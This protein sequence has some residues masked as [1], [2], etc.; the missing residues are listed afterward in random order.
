MKKVLLSLAVIVS[1]ISCNSSEEVVTVS[2]NAYSFERNG[3]STVNFEGQTTRI[4]MANELAKALKKQSTETLQS[5]KGKFAHSA[6]ENNFSE[7]DLN[8][9]SKNIR[10]K[11][12]ASTDY[13]TANTTAATAIKADFDSWISGQVNTVFPNWNQ[14]ASKG[15]AGQIQEAGGGAIRWVN[16]KGLEYDQAI[17]KGLIGGL[18]V[19][20]ILNNYLSKAVLDAGTNVEDNNAELLLSGK[21]YTTME[22]KWDEA[23]GYLYGNEPSITAPVLNT[24]SYLN[25]YLSRVEGDD[26]FKGIAKEIYD[27]F[28]LGRAAIVAKDYNLRNAQAE[29]IKEKI[30]EIVAIRAVYYLQQAKATLVNNKAAAFHDLSEGFGFIYSLQFTRKPNTNEPYFTKNEVVAF[31]DTLMQNDGFWDVTTT[32]LDEMAETISAK[33]SF[34]LT[35]A[36]S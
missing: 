5:L 26:D 4:K 18:M 7:P 8:S 11:V 35:Q 29:I 33:F 14:N 21:N 22:H 1:L 10:S 17:V 15:I 24:D 27:A 28:K 16:A 23:F 12:A 32:T 9:S 25:K 3:S 30:S 6:G 13:F 36:G 31:V 34:T 20:Q 2:P 19:D